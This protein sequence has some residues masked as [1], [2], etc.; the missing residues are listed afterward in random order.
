MRKIALISTIF[1]IIFTS[2][3]LTS[4][5]KETKISD[6]RRTDFIGGCSVGA[7]AVASSARIAVTFDNIMEN[8][9]RAYDKAKDDI[10]YQLDFLHKKMNKL[11]PT[12]H[13][14]IDRYKSN[15]KNKNNYKLKQPIQKKYKYKY[16]F[17]ENDHNRV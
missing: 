13:R 3:A 1:L 2:F 15:Q 7:L 9:I 12:Q 17:K 6:T 4:K 5:S 8:C 16:K 10:D 11:Q 14:F